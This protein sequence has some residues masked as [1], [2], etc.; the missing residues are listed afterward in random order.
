VFSKLLRKISST[1][2]HPASVAQVD[3]GPKRSAQGIVHDTSRNIVELVDRLRVADSYKYLYRGQNGAYGPNGDFTRQI[4]AVFRG[5]ETKES[6]KAAL[7]MS[8]L[9]ISWIFDRVRE[10][11]QLP[12]DELGPQWELHFAALHLGDL[13]R[14]Q[15]PPAMLGIAQHYGIPTENLDLTNLD[16]AAVFAT[17]RWLSI[18]EAL[19]LSP[20]T[21]VSPD[22]PAERGFIYRYDTEKLIDLGVPVGDLS[23]GNAGAR[24]IIQEARSVALDFNQDIDLFAAGGYEVFPFRMSKIPYVYKRQIKPSPLLTGKQRVVLIDL[25]EAFRENAPVSIRDLVVPRFFFTTQPDSTEPWQ[26]YVGERPDPLLCLG[27]MIEREL[28]KC[29]ET[30]HV[31]SYAQQLF[32]NQYDECIVSHSLVKEF[33]ILEQRRIKTFRDAAHTPELVEI[34]P[35]TF[36]M[37]SDNVPSQIY[38]DETPSQPKSVNYR[39]AIGKYPVTFGELLPFFQ[40]TQPE[41]VM[42]DLI[43]E[44][45]ADASRLPAI[46]VSWHEAKAYCKWLSKV[47]GH[48]YRLLTEMEWE[49]ACRAGTST[50]YWWGDTFDPW[51]ANCRSEEINLFT[52]RF[53]RSY[54]ETR[55]QIHFLTPVD[56]F[57]PNPWGICDMNGNVWEWVEDV[58]DDKRTNPQ[59]AA[60]KHGN[61]RFRSLRGGSWMDPALSLRSAAR[62][63]AYPTAQDRNIGFR[64]VRDL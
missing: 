31:I 35:G 5:C 54:S 56:K 34:L 12:I 26:A 1:R 43:E 48:K 22:K 14:P 32:G 44:V 49:Y 41:S 53:P 58:Y 6:A 16:P 24:P 15:S 19:K 61:E 4:P 46:G 40:A 11:Q 28:H 27:R 59:A 33:A 7:A 25:W 10:G 2:K 36:V 30:P 18:D 13:S 60:P 62:S 52:E 51:N 64:I 8:R 17:Q 63:W 45:G 3:L 20:G 57:D 21:T 37:G 55:N 29:S 39:F 38:I 50:E 23:S 47:T 42:L 9:R